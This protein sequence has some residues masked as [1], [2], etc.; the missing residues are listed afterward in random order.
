MVRRKKLLSGV[1]LLSGM[2]CTGQVMAQQWLYKQAAVPIE[3]RVKDLLG[4]MT[5]EEKVGQLCCPLGWEMY[6]KTGKN[7]VTVS[8]LYKKKMA[9]APVGSF[10][11]V[12][13][14]DPWTQKTLE[15]G[16][17]PE[18]SAKALNALQKYAVEETRLG[19]PVLFAEE[20][21]HGHMAIGTTV[22]PTALSA[23]ST[24]N[25][26]LMLK[27]GEAIALEA[28]L[29]GANIGY[30]PVLDIA[31]EPRWSRMEETFGEDP[32][33]TTIMGVAMMKG[34]Q[35]KVQNDGKHLYATLK[36]FAAYG[37]PESGHNGSRAN[38]GMRQL[39][40][41]YLPPFR[42]AVEEGAG[43]LMTSYNAIDGVPCT[44]NKELLTDVLR[45]Q[46]GFKGFVYSDLISIEGIVGMRAAKDNKEAA[47]KALKAGL[48]MDLGGNAFG[49]NLK[50]A[51][52][53]GLITMA[54]L[55][56]AVGNVLRLKFQMGLFENP[57]VSPEL[58]KK[59]V[60]SKEHKELARQVAREGVVLLKNEGV[61][62]LSKHIGHL[63][64]IGPN[65]DEMYNQ[66]GD[67]T[68]PQVRE[69]VATVL[70]G[71]RAAV[72]ESTR[73]TYVK[74]CAVRDTTATDIPAAVAAAQKADAVV[75]VVGGSSARDFKTKYIST[76]AATVSEDAKTLPDMDCGE[77]FDRSSLRLL[78]DQ[79]K[80]IS[81]VASTGK[82]LV[83]VYIQGRTMNMN[84]AAE[85]AQALLTAWYPGEQGG[86]G[87]ADILFGDYSPAGRLP[88]SVPRSEG[89][90]P[91]FYSQGTQRDYVESKG[92]PLYAFGYGLSYTRFTYSG[93]ELQKGT[94]METLQTVACTVTNTGNRDGEEVVQLY[95][96]DKVASV[97]QPPLLLKAFQRI[98]LKKGESRQV[99]F[100]LKKDDLAIYDSEMNYVVEPG[101]FKVMVGAASNDIRLEGEF[102]L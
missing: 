34:M 10:W 98:F 15:T 77:G 90:L 65:A 12:L 66:L 93:L 24:W 58:A 91:V 71:I 8:E 79:E 16:L 21:P 55:D 3:Y 78:G 76:G 70:D 4:R 72:S 57:Y 67:Y 85:K 41:E 36:H 84:L 25:E 97:S 38:C 63:A 100:H 44:A 49:K 51:Y 35:G 95:I 86:M 83:V 43:T 60:H 80:L 6:T 92:T 45:N 62:P 56:R 75:L 2:L 61:L 17:S 26:G 23:A 64:V 87:I 30:G 50:K 47:V 5:I 94:E 101:E 73:V 32:V 1:L 81:A 42:K 33:L 54:D 37:V 82:P 28:R 22:F 48:D 88:V 20:C 39:L 18:L 27:M 40:S 9:E 69:E 14:A 89:Q 46:W 29:Q 52:E 102:V 74:G 96:G 68:A 59:L 19:I 13:R 31:R 7:E 53:E 99:I 11:A